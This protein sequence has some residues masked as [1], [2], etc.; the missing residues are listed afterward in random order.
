MTLS[1]SKIRETIATDSVYCIKLAFTCVCG[2]G[3]GVIYQRPAGCRL[4]LEHYRALSY[5][6]PLSLI[7]SVIWPVEW[8]PFAM[9][10]NDL[11]CHPADV[12]LTNGINRTFV[13]HCARFQLTQRVALSLG[14]S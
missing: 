5:C 1:I 12:R 13:Q 14:D 11:E 8:L 7:G 6:R 2:I 9:T 10:L 4:E 3:V